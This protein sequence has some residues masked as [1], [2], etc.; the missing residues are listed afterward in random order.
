MLRLRLSEFESRPVELTAEAVA[1]LHAT[2]PHQ[3]DV[4]A[5]G[6]PGRYLLTAKHHVGSIRGPDLE[7]R[8]EP[9]V[10]TAG[11]FHMVGYAH[12]LLDLGRE[13]I[14]H[15]RSDDLY[16]ILLL[17]LA[18]YL[19]ELVLGRLRRGYVERSEDLPVVRGRLLI[20]QVLRRLAATSLRVPCRHEEFTADLP[21]NQVIRHALEALPLPRDVALAR[22][23]RRLRGT[24]RFAT[25]K[26]FVPSDIDAF[27][28]DRLT[29]HYEPIHRLCRLLLEASGVGEREGGHPFA[30]FLIDMNKLFERFVAEW[31]RAHLP[32]EYTVDTQVHGYLDMGRQI[33]IRPDLVLRRRGHTVLVADTKYKRAKDGGPGAAD[34][35]QLLAYCRALGIRTGLL[36]YPMPLGPA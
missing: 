15:D 4:A 12:G 8:I 35:Y 14:E 6:E 18:G 31:L 1:Y 5:T 16:D 25:R 7:I 19:E 27:H 10:G 33:P 23:I 32:N 13:R 36:I 28:Y 21:H 2:F 22:R 26:R 30:T 9:K 24:F 3:L 34:A 29:D 20:D 11:L 17:V